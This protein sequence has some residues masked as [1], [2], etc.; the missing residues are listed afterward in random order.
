MPGRRIKI[1]S[2]GGAELGSVQVDA[3]DVITVT[4]EDAAPERLSRLIHRIGRRGVLVPVDDEAPPPGYEYAP[5]TPKTLDRVL[6]EVDNLL[7]G[8]EY[9]TLSETVG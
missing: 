7:P 4:V 6:D 8:L 5:L 2:T 9:Q 1:L 3:D